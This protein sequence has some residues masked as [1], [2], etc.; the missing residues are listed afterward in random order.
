MTDSRP[1]PAAFWDKAFG[2]SEYRYGK[3][4]NA[5]IAETLPKLLK[6]GA[7]VL[8]VGDG[9]GRNGVWCARQGYQ[10][11]SLEPSSAGIQKTRALADEFGV[12]INSIQ[13]V[14]PSAQIKDQS[15]DAVVLTYIHALPGTREEIHQACVRALAPGGVIVLEGFTPAQR[16]RGLTSGGP[17]NMAMLFT[18]SML[19]DDF[20][21][22]EIEY[23]EELTTTL[24]EGP[25]HQG[26]AEVIRLI[27][28]R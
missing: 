10:T 8:C 14:M 22:L 13:D 12:P 25:G 11:T 5:F 2:N 28:R 27:A 4:P 3:N 16:E 21:D 6:E 1:D 9:E 23:I 18:E 26:E 19:Q 20:K 24:N 17:G 7:R 15:F